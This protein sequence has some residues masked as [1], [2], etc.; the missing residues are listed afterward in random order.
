M[1]RLRKPLALIVFGSVLALLVGEV[2][3]RV[4][5]SD[6]LQFDLAWV[7]P[8][9]ELGWRNRERWN[10]TFQFEGRTIPIHTNELGL[11]G[12]RAVEAR[13]S[14]TLRVLLLG[15]S[16]TAGYEVPESQTFAALLE[17]RL[18]TY[19][20]DR[21]VEVL[22]AGT[23]GWSTDQAERFLRRVALPLEPEVVVYTF[24]SNDLSGNIDPAKPRY[25]RRGR[26]MRWASPPPSRTRRADS[27]LRRNSYLYRLG[28]FL[29]IRRETRGPQGEAGAPRWRLEQAGLYRAVPDREPAWQLT[30]ELLR[31]MQR[32]C[33]ERNIAFFVMP[34]VERL[35]VL[36]ST[37][38]EFRRAG[39][40][41]TGC[42]FN[43]VHATLRNFCRAEGIG[44]ID[45]RVRF[46]PEEQCWGQYDPHWNALGHRRAA[47][48]LFEAMRPIAMERA[49][50]V[51]PGDE[52]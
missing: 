13:R 12:Q 15:D 20:P 48:A 35:E 40:D 29:H 16:T 10:G 33:R 5:L 45:A 49:T 41:L 44:F 18:Q 38:E 23:R 25:V 17:R 27:W 34:F 4:F 8:D 42:D 2:A 21:P 24:C 39:V 6:R 32:L 22:N 26:E 51:E 50:R 3:L 9:T 28:V 14:A 43:L 11:R 52:R 31:R 46:Q 7:R 37:R 30:F 47:E 19:L 1:R 36:E